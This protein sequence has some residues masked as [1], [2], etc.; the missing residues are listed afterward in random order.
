MSRHSVEPPPP[1]LHQ[2]GTD[3][4][5]L[6]TWQRWGTLLLPFA[7][8][9]AYAW[10]STH[11]YWLTAGFATAGYT[12]Y[13]YGSTSHDLVHA[14][15]GWPRWFNNLALSLVELCG[16]RSGHAYRAAHLHHHA[17]FPVEDDVEAAA[18]H[19]T[20]GQALLAG[21]K[22]QWNIVL[23]A[24][25]HASRQDR[26]WII[27][28]IVGCG[29]IV[30]LAMIGLP[31]S[32][33]LLVW[34]VLV[35]LGSWTFPLITAYMPHHARGDNVLT[36][37][38]R[39]RGTLY[40]V[41]FREHLYHLEHHLYPAVPH[42][43]WPT[44]AR[45]LDTYLDRMGVPQADLDPHWLTIWRALGHGWDRCRRAVR[46]APFVYDLLRGHRACRFHLKSST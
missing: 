28:E 21:P 41:L 14:N 26:R 1:P 5:E 29:L 8:V 31:Y 33:P 13:S 23:W 45:R 42:H 19:G 30:T 20:L 25:R 9:T 46:M 3:L 17:R 40:S 32:M 35:V 37:T 39:F 15:A 2:L 24:L 38:Y 10:L 36:Q 22:H 6:S 27:G 16:L 11:G 43:H 4:L 12:F 7:W 18:A 34:S 44:L